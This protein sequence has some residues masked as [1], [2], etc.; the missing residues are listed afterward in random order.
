MILIKGLWGNG[1]YL[2]MIDCL[3]CIPDKQKLNY[4]K[5]YWDKH[6]FYLF[7]IFRWKFVRHWWNLHKWHDAE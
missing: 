5:K 7:E 4:D 6:K 3:I 1:F 2:W